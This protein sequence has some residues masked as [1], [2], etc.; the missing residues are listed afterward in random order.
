[1]PGD[2]VRNV[3]ALPLGENEQPIFTIRQSVTLLLVQLVALVLVGI[4]I[5][6]IFLRTDRPGEPALIFGLTLGELGAILGS[7]AVGFVI[8][9]RFLE[10]LTTIYRLTTR[11]IQKDF[12]ILRKTSLAIPVDE[13]ETVDI[14]QSIFGRILGYGSV[15]MRAT[16]GL[17]KAISFSSVSQPALR[18]E[19]V[20]DALR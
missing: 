2:E 8:L 1:M 20:E 11:R 7:F 12:G 16:G 6:L 19:Q 4:L 17:I 5:V 13:I 10:W 15:D 14:Q 9:I 18:R 3:S